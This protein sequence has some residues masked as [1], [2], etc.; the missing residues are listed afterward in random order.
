MARLLRIEFSGALYRLTARGNAQH[1][2]ELYTQHFNKRHKRMGYIFL[3]RFKG[4]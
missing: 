3:G 4:E 2:N 1:N